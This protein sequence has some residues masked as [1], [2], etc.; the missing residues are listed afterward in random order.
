MVFF[1]R[2][3]LTGE[4]IFRAQKTNFPVREKMSHDVLIFLTRICLLGRQ[5]L[6]LVASINNAFF[7]RV[8]I[9]YPASSFTLTNTTHLPKFKM[10]T[11]FYNCAFVRKL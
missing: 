5:C 4:N 6:L 11:A 3:N 2:A 7:N 1:K 8:S 10:N 9:C